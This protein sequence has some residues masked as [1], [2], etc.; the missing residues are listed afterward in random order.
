MR[1]GGVR[2]AERQSRQWLTE[3]Q[4]PVLQMSLYCQKI[5]PQLLDDLYDSIVT[6]IKSSCAIIDW[7]SCRLNATS[8]VFCIPTIT[9]AV[10]KKVPIT[11]E[12]LWFRWAAAALFI[13]H[14]LGGS[15][16][17]SDSNDGQ[18]SHPNSDLNL[19][20]QKTTCLIR[21]GGIEGAHWSAATHHPTCPGPVHC[22]RAYG[23]Q[24]CSHAAACPTS[25]RPQRLFAWIPHSPRQESS[26]PS[27]VA[28]GIGESV[29]YPLWPGLCAH[30]PPYGP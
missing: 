22:G 17:L 4:L 11:S 14:S 30:C 6:F 25:P 29:M 3:P 16:G 28:T 8:P 23:V 13:P 15:C 10:P 26:L 12:T 21:N 20:R 18:T 27:V 9:A 24:V 2:A 7:Y 1:G 19:Q 5:V